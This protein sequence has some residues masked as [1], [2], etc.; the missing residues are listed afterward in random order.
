MCALPDTV[1]WGAGRA[2]PAAQAE[3]RLWVPK[4]VPAADDQSHVD[5]WVRLLIKASIVRLR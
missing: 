2:V 3:R 5:F 4:A 1:R